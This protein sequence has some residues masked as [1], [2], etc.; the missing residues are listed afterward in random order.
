MHRRQ[1]ASGDG[2]RFVFRGLDVST[3]GEIAAAV[4]LIACVV[5][6]LGGAEYQF[7]AASGAAQGC[8]CGFGCSDGG[9]LFGNGFSR[10][11]GLGGIRAYGLLNVCDMRFLGNSVDLRVTR[12]RA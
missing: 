9:L 1:A 3:L 8:L 4:E 6:P 7:A 2:S 11:Y 10:L 5:A 12:S